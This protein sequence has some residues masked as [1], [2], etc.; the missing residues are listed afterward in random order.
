MPERGRSAR[1]YT[2][3]DFLYT[4]IQSLFGSFTDKVMPNSPR[5]QV[6]F[7]GRV[8][9]RRAAAWSAS[10]IFAQSGWFVDQ[11]NVASV[12]RLHAGQPA[13]DL[14]AR[15][16]AVPDGAVSCRC[17][18][19][20]APEYIAFTEPDPDGNSYQPGPTREAFLGIKITFGGK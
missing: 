19:C 7:D 8:R 1:A 3:N 15:Q 12:E 6:A 13:R 9:L 17:G 14:P 20:S 18:T 16:G 2:F 5:H 11:T 4:T 10:A